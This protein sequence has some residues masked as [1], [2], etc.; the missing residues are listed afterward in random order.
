[1]AI[2]VEILNMAIEILE[3]A[4]LPI[5]LA[6]LTVYIVHWF[7]LKRAKVEQDEKIVRQLF[8]RCLDALT[9]TYEAMSICFNVLNQYANSPPTSVRQFN[10]QVLA[11]KDKWEQVEQNNA[12]WLKSIEKE[13]S[14]VRGE[15][16]MVSIEISRKVRNPNYTMNIRW[17]QFSDAFFTARDAIRNLVPISH[18]EK[19]LKQISSPTP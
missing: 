19:R 16:R 6:L 11:V 15:F 8:G 12:I 18:L 17:K 1:M 10:R 13:I 14:A 2:S 4:V 7:E 5:V 3:K 9:Q